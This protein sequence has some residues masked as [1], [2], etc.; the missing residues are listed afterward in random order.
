MG[1]KKDKLYNAA[2]NSPSNIRFQD[3]CNLA[4]EVGFKL[5]K[6]KGSHRIY[7]HPNL[8]EMMT[9][10]PDKGDSSKAK[11]YQVRQLLS[12]IEDNDLL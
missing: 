9:F 2:K 10:Q 11:A 6:I 8:P 12:C 4:E 7:K 5:R 3:L 1:S